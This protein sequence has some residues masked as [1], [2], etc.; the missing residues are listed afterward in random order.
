MHNNPKP[1]DIE[2]EE[3]KVENEGDEAKSSGEASPL[4]ETDPSIKNH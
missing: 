1:E 4:S 3:E 2:N